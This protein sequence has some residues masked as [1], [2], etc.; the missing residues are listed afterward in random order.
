MTQK[1]IPALYFCLSTPSL[2][3]LAMEPEGG[4]EPS[5]ILVGTFSNGFGI[6]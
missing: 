5:L 1:T 4:L 6:A 2:E 3:L